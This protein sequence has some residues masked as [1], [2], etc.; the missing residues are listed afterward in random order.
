MTKKLTRCV[1]GLR[2]EFPGGLRG[3]GGHGQDAAI[4]M[5]RDC[6]NKPRFP[7]RVAQSVPKFFDRG[8]QAV[9]EGTEGVLGPESLT[10]F[11]PGN[12]F[13]GVLQQQREQPE[14]LFLQLYLDAFLVQLSRTKIDSKGAEAH[15]PQTWN[16]SINITFELMHA[17][18]HFEN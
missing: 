12:N 7:R 9:I 1:W 14:R 18:Y 8:V 5:F 15:G 6:C 16:G 2:G 3:D 17:L 11:I 13:A 4:S 10:Q